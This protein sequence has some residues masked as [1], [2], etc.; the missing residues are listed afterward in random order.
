MQPASF[1]RAE[2]ANHVHDGSCLGILVGSL[3]DDN[4]QHYAHPMDTCLLSQKPPRPCPYFEAVGLPIADHPSPTGDPHRQENYLD[5]KLRYLAWRKKDG[6]V[7]VS[8]RACP[9]CGQPVAKRKRYCERCAG[10]RKRTGGNRQS[11][12]VISH[13]T[14]E[15]APQRVSMGKIREAVG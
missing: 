5:A 13:Q 1:A 4:G 14:H 7:T 11:N 6:E 12:G 10:I 9:D 3:S 8:A 15:D 2:C